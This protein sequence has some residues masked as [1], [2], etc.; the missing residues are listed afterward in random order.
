M[1]L[2]ELIQVAIGK[3][4][5]LLHNPS[6]KEWSRLYMDAMKQSVAGLAFEG[7]QKLPKE[8]CPPQKLLF[9][10][11]AISEQIKH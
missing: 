6:D 2:F 5:S 11:L 3:R 7:I 4:T 8:Q 9:Q 1:M 10:W